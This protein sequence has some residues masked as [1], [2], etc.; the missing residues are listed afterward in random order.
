MYVSLCMLYVCRKS[1][2]LIQRVF[3]YDP[4]YWIQ[5]KISLCNVKDRQVAGENR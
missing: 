1:S 4:K 2:K 5:E 3:Y